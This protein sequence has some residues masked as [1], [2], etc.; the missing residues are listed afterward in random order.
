MRKPRKNTPQFSIS[1]THSRSLHWLLLSKTAKAVK[2]NISYKVQG[3]VDRD[4]IIISLSS[5]VDW[6]SMKVCLPKKLQSVLNH[7][8]ALQN[9]CT[10]I[11]IIICSIELFLRFI[12]SVFVV[13]RFRCPTIFLVQ[14]KNQRKSFSFILPLSRTTDWLFDCS[15]SQ[16]HPRIR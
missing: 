1:I 7:R 4:E 10:I 13:R 16:R 5:I 14:L 9:L 12:N 8:V 11:I 6:L 2:K 15:R 3:R